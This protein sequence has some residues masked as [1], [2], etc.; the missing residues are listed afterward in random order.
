M[1]LA[2]QS[3]LESAIAEIE[4]M[5]QI[6]VPIEHYFADGVY[7]RLGRLKKGTNFGGRV[8]LQSQIN[9]I[10]SGDVNLLDEHGLTRL[11]GPCVWT[12]PAGAQRA[13][14]VNEDTV[15]ITVLGTHE[16]DPAVIF[17]KCTRRTQGE[18]AAAFDEAANIIQE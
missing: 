11:I 14:Y 18:A 2:I 12:S 10:L 6:E 8:H 1:N 5:P 16:T 9:I 7:G 15:W 3:R 4:Q 17:E 13:A